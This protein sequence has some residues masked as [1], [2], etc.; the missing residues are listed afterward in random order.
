MKVHAECYQCFIGQAIRSAKFHRSDR[1]GLLEPVKNVVRVLQDIDVEVPPPL[2][3]ED[4]YGTIKKTLGI[5][6]PYAEIKKKYNDIALSYEEFMKDEIENSENPLL[7]AI[8][9]ALAGNIIDFGSQ[10][11][12]FD[13]ESVID[14]TVRNPLDMT[15]FALFEKSIKK[16]KKVVL[17]ADNAG[18]IVFDKILLKTI[19]TLYPDMELYAIVRG[20]PVINDVTMDDALYVGLDEIAEVVSSGQVI[21][22]FWPETASKY[23]RD[24]FERADIVI[25]K[26]QGNFETLSEFEDE[27]VYFLF[28]VKCSVVARYLGMKKLSKIFVRNDKK[29]ERQQE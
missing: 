23:A 4:V 12:S 1:Y 6:D 18:E 22:G 17:L 9:L 29:W 3:S 28:L 21:P 20:A 11:K 26:G 27:R 7:F 8:R 13:L 2:I 16:A 25:S 19:K 10:I 15:D 24:V 5:E 14:E